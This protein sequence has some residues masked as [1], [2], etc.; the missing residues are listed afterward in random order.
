[1]R[2]RALPAVLALSLGLL[3]LP[4]GVRAQQQAAAP[5]ATPPERWK[6][7][8]DLGFTAASGNERLAVLTSAVSLTHLR[9]E[10]FEL[11]LDGD[12]RYGRSEGKEVARR[13]R[14]GLKFDLYPHSMW[15]PFFFTTGEHDRFRR[16]DLRT[17]G[18][19]GIKHTFWDSPAGKAS[20]SL[21]VVYSYEDYDVAQLPLLDQFQRNTR[22]SWRLKAQRQLGGAVRLESTTFYQPLWNVAADY[23]VEAETALTVRISRKLGVSL[24]HSYNRDSRPPSPDVRKDDHLVKVGL[25]LEL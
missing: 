13:F 15:S 4:L 20:L 9:Q 7:V 21:A 5:P 18:G 8:V 25:S 6:L 19:A 14:G 10:L 17:S 1:M 22:W 16:L 12:L 11:A 2:A 23:L 3:A 24:G